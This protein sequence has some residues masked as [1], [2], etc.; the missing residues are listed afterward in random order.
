[1]RHADLA[2]YQAK[3]AG[4]NTYRVYEPAM[5]DELTRQL[6]LES[7]LRFALERGELAVHFQPIVQVTNGQLAGA[8]ALL[9]WHHPQRGPV[10]VSYTHLDVYK[11]QDFR[12]DRGCQKSADHAALAGYGATG[13]VSGVQS[14]AVEGGSGQNGGGW[15]I[16]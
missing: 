6:R 2:M 15:L 4:R 14:G 10:P 3:L 8:E 16:A 12:A 11:R 7:D 13:A 1:M 5:S 9:R